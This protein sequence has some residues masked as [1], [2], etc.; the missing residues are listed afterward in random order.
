MTLIL[1]EKQYINLELYML[2]TC[3]KDGILKE[4]INIETTQRL[5][6]ERYMYH[7]VRFF[8]ACAVMAML[9]GAGPAFAQGIHLVEYFGKGC[10]HGSVA[11]SLAAERKCASPQVRA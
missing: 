2:L 8:F 11:Q 7:L 3:S 6:K 5:L 4:Y 1:L 9:V 10:P